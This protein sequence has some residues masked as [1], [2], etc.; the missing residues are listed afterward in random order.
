LRCRRTPTATDPS[1]RAARR[2]LQ[3]NDAAGALAALDRYE[4]T[5]SKHSLAREALLLR[6]R[7]LRQAGRSAEAHTLGESYIA[8]HPGDGYVVRLQRELGI[9]APS[10]A[11]PSAPAS[12][13][14]PTASF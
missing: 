1:P 12:A 9:P 10:A 13:K 7:A 3:S 14:V 11:A 2:A 6:V 8:R 5:P 4:R